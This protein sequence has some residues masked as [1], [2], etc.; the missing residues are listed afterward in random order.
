M[1]EK[2]K[3]E[4]L[5]YKIFGLFGP[6]GRISQRLPHFGLDEGHFWCCGKGGHF[7]LRV[8]RLLRL[9]YW[10]EPLYKGEKPI[11]QLWNFLTKTRRN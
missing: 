1:I 11:Y 3:N 5:L 8:D 10:Q 9:W 6:D 7:F 2:I 4:Y